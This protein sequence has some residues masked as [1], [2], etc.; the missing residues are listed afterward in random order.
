MKKNFIFT[1]YALAIAVFFILT[2]AFSVGSV[3]MPKT[4]WLS[5]VATDGH[6]DIEDSYITVD[7]DRSFTVTD[8]NGETI[9]ENKAIS[10]IYVYVGK[11]YDK[12]ADDL[13]IL[14]DFKTKSSSS[15]SY[16][17]E[18]K[19]SG[20]RQYSWYCVYDG[21]KDGVIDNLS[22]V[23][24]HTPDVFEFYEVAF[25]A[26][27]GE[28]IKIERVAE[29]SEYTKT[30]AEYLIDE[31]ST[32][33]SSAAYR[34]NLGDEEL[35]ELKAADSLF[36]GE[37]EVGTGP[38]TTFL[39]AI[40]IA[41]FG[42]NTFG[43]R[44]VSLLLGYISFIVLYLLIKRI[45]N[46]DV[47]A[48]I[49]SLAAL[50][51]SALFI[52]SASA[53]LSV[54][55]T[56]ILLAYYLAIGF[57]AGIYKFEYKKETVFN[58]IFSGLAI[59]FAVSC[60]VSNIIF[61]IGIP[62][63]WGMSLKKLN[64]EY[65]V[66]Y[67]EAKG[68]KKESIYTSYHKKTSR[69]GYLLPL[70]FI[71]I[72]LVLTVIFYAVSASP[73]KAHYGTGF[74]VAMLRDMGSSFGFDF[75]IGRLGI[76]IG[77]DGNVLLN[78]VPYVAALIGFIFTTS[79][80]FAPKNSK[81]HKMQSG[82]KVKYTILTIMLVFGFAPFLFG[83]ANHTAAAFFSCV[84]AAYIPLLLAAIGKVAKKKALIITTAVIGAIGLITF[85]GC[86]IGICGF[87]VSDALAK[88][89]YGWQI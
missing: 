77:K 63:V 27:N 29:Y 23:K 50:F 53:S 28:R 17:K 37:G 59:G 54:G 40:S 4:Y 81:A 65:K 55:V 6:G 73:V 64:S 57:Y 51:M 31:Q 26:E 18:V 56:F 80:F 36:K 52:S 22:R 30:S 15:T 7:L 85:V 62:I 60:G 10:G 21:S 69:Y 2:G 45:F 78:Y 39:N 14:F 75:S 42:R 58:L 24:I 82:I 44:V 74:I 83:L 33:T 61:L 48:L 16:V 8:A 71:V 67:D 88:I 68:L 19:A 72:P 89:L 11:I 41:V 70:T 49:G 34:F 9:T 46:S 76:F 32:F 1:I 3:N 79:L 5:T 38:F 47:Y 43:I 87:E 20:V 84:Y 12:S 25:T 13:T 35:L 86:Y 66:A